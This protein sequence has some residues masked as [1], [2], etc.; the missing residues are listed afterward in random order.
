MQPFPFFPD[1]INQDLHRFYKFS[2]AFVLF[3]S[4]MAKTFIENQYF[5]I[6]TNLGLRVRSTL[7]SAIYQKALDLGPRAM[8]NMTVKT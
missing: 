8:K 7:S 1:F 2:L 3:G 6:S 4:L 5:D